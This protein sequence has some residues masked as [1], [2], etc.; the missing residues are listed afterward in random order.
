VIA[1]KRTRRLWRTVWLVVTRQHP[2]YGQSTR[3]LPL[4]DDAPVTDIERGNLD[5]N[6][7]REAVRHSECAGCRGA[8]SGAD[9]TQPMRNWHDKPHRL[10]YD[11]CN[12]VDQL[13][14]ALKVAS[15]AP[16]SYAELTRRGLTLNAVSEV[17]RRPM[18]AF[19]DL[20]RSD[21]TPDQG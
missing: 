2:V 8:F 5:T 16:I 7:Y 3:G 4:G 15:G 18:A 11:L 6:E 20:E 12:E 17:L 1:V 13:R 9:H 19:A 14:E 10:V 21:S